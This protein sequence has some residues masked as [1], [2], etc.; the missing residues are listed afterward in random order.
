[1]T[2]KNINLTPIQQHQPHLRLIKPADIDKHHDR[3]RHLAT[4]KSRNFDSFPVSPSKY[5]RNAHPSAISSS[6]GRR[7]AMLA[8]KRTTR[9]ANHIVTYP[10]RNL[11]IGELGE[12][13]KMCDMQCF[14]CPVPRSR[15]RE[16]SRSVLPGGRRYGQM[17][18]WCLSEEL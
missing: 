14:C 17:V 16:N 7:D 10:V 18:S 2:T 5:P 4:A 13:G 12:G 15:E 6:A 3:H 1:M 9:A 8:S 11:P